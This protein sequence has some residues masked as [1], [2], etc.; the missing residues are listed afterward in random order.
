MMYI[1]VYI[2]NTW[3]D[4]QK[5]EDADNNIVDIAKTTGFRFLR[6]MIA[7]RPV[8]CSMRFTGDD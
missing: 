3:I 6:M 5:F 2:K 7:S 8:D 4:L 1:N